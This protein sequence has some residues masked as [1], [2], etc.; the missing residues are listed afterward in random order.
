MTELAGKA[1]VVTGGGSGVGRAVAH[2]LAAE[3]VRVVVADIVKDNAE[4]VAAEIASADGTAIAVE[5]D[6]SDRAAVRQLKAAANAA[7]GA[8]L[9]LIPNAGATSFKPLNGIS[10]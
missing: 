5:C 9:I 2:A 4:A 3:G 1:A 8:I 10:D 7:F 6:V